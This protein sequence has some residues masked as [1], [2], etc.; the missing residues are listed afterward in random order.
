MVNSREDDLQIA[1]YLKN[2]VIYVFPVLN[3]DGYEYS[4]TEA[5]N[6]KVGDENSLPFKT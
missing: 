2:L 6:P 4:R 1:S 3:P 5:T